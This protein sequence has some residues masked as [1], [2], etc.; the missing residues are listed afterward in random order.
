[1]N[2]L[3]LPSLCSLKEES[4]EGLKFLRRRRQTVLRKI[5][6][7]MSHRPIH[8]RSIKEEAKDC[9]GP[10]NRLSLPSLCLLK[11]V[12][13]RC[14]KFLRHRRQRAHRKYQFPFRFRFQCS[15]RPIHH[16]S[17]T[18]EVWLCPNLQWCQ[19]CR[20]CQYL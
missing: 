2:R 17:S 5:L 12:V 10:M 16:S 1:M 14:L 9:Q 13:A 3:S 4:A 7:Q 15:N 18:T 20:L 8:H 19:L 6:Y 11:E